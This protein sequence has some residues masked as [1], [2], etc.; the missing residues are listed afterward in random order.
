MPILIIVGHYGKVEED[1]DGTLIS[2]IRC[3]VVGIINFVLIGVASILVRPLGTAQ[4]T[5]GK[6]G[7]VSWYLFKNPRFVILFVFGLITTFGF[8]VSELFFKYSFGH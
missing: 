5:G 7:M 8:L 1:V 6:A 4:Q 2:S 3:S